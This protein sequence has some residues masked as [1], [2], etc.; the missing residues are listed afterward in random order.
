MD[1]GGSPEIVAIALEDWSHGGD[2]TADHS[3]HSDQ[4][5]NG[6]NLAE[7]MALQ[8]FAAALQEAQRIAVQ[9]EGD[10]TR[11]CKIPKTYQGDLRTTLY[12]CEK[13][14]KAL[15]LKGFLDIRTFLAMKQKDLCEQEHERE[16]TLGAS[17]LDTSG[18]LTGTSHIHGHGPIARGGCTEEEGVSQRRRKAEM[19]NLPQIAHK[20]L[21]AL[22]ALES[23]RSFAPWTWET[24]AHA[25]WMPWRRGGSRGGGR[26]WQ[27]STYR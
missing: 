2:P 12:C 14:Q 6:P 22:M 25:V 16:R 13:T 18:F 26:S 1:D 11:K 19:S 9:L 15:A 4:A 17:G 3:D 5:S 7:Q 8:Q 27:S 10:Q 20:I 21:L 23:G 24:S